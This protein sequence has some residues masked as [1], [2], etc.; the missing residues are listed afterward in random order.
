MPIPSGVDVIQ[1][2]HI[3]CVR[4]TDGLTIRAQRVVYDT[5]TPVCW[6]MV[7]EDRLGRWLYIEHIEGGQRATYSTNELIK[8]AKNAGFGEWEQSQCGHRPITK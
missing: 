2:D 7:V 6:M 5:E 4:P 1:F 3:Q 8:L